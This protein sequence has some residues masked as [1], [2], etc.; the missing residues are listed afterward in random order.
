MRSAR[1]DRAH[2]AD[3]DAVERG[4]GAVPAVDR[5]HIPARAR[6]GT[7]HRREHMGADGLVR[8]AVV[9]GTSRVRFSQVRELASDLVKG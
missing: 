5:D 7:R 8:V 6:F 9:T 4:L 1:C 3:A 2:L